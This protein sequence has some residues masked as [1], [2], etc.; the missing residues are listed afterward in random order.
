MIKFYNRENELA[1]LANAKKISLTQSR[2]T[3]ITGRRRI[4]KTSLILKATE[5]D[6]FIYLFVA[7]KSESLL[8]REFTEEISQKLDIPVIGEINSFSKLFE[9]LLIQ[10]QSQP[11]TLAIDEFQEFFNINP[12]VYSDMQNI[13]DRYKHTSKMNLLLSGSIYSMMKKIFENT[14]EPL[15]G[16]ANEKINLK[17]FNIN[18]LKEILKDEYPDFKKEDLLAFYILTGGVAKYVEWFV[19]KKAFTLSKM[20]NELFRENS[21]LLDEGKNLLIEE[22]GK[23]YTT[24][25]SILSLIASSKT[26]RSEIESILEKNIGGYLDRLEKDYGIIKVVRPILSKPGGRLQKYVI[27]DNFLNF[28][29]RFIYKN[30]SAIEIGNFDHLKKIVKRDFETYSGRLLE[31]YFLEKLSLTYKYSQLGSYWERNNKNEIDIVGVNEIDKKLLVAEVK[32][33]K[34]KFNKN[35]LME[36]AARLIKRFRDYDIQFRLFSLKDM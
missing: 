3:I 20:L 15:F 34:E 27:E 4:G 22:F 9:F 7:R 35:I 16:R 21:L 26:S 6:K 17:P 28:W 33:N 2:M 36:K 29:F 23:D 30:R 10:S 32:L 25:F 19:Q 13:W 11:F 5:N 24:Y 12:S 1:T 18:V 8:C 31:K 14:K